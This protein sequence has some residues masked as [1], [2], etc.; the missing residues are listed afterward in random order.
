MTFSPIPAQV[1]SGYNSEKIYQIL[2]QNILDLTLK[3][4]ETLTENMLCQQFHV[5]RTPI[6]AAMQRL[7][8]DNLLQVTPYKGSR[9]ALLDFEEIQEYIYMRSAVESAVLRDFLEIC[10]P[11]HEEKIRYQIRKQQVLLSADFPP[12]QFYEMDARLHGLWFHTTKKAGLWQ[13]IQKAQ[14]N[15]TRFRMLDIVAEQNFKEI[16][17]EHQA[18]FRIIRQGDREAVDPLIQKHLNGGIKRLG[19]RLH[20]EFS[21][22]FVRHD[23]A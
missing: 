3:P 10:T 5:S 16:I 7:Q 13:M 1:G 22:Y 15:Y 4:G 14:V 19:E 23:E 21:G 12:G 8:S 17:Q 20:T 2:R 18:L 11:L 9:V 6:R